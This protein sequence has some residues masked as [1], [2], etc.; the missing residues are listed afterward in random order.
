MYVC[1]SGP[2]L[3]SCGATLSKQSV[4]VK[5][6][7]VLRKGKF[8]RPSNSKAGVSTI[9]TTRDVCRNFYQLGSSFSLQCH[10]L[11]HGAG[12]RLQTRTLLSPIAKPPMVYV[13]V[14]AE[15]ANRK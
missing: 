7:S 14:A 13:A 6:S 10:P 4:Q 12:Q 1:C 3:L 8:L 9:L 2:L 11:F 5:W 15:D